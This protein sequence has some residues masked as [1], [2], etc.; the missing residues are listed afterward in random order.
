M[1]YDVDLEFL[2]VQTTLNALVNIK[3]AWINTVVIVSAM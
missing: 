1:K 3:K 2:T